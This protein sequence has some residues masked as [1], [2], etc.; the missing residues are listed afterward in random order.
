MHGVLYGI[1]RNV[2]S[3]YTVIYALLQLFMKI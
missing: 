3:A 1:Q 2:E